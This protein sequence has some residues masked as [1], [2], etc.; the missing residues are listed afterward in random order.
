ME[1]SKVG[2]CVIHDGDPA[3]RQRWAFHLRGAGKLAENVQRKLLEG[4]SRSGVICVGCRS[5]SREVNDSDLDGFEFGLQD[6]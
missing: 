6:A 2:S 1:R 5:N 4:L 3:I